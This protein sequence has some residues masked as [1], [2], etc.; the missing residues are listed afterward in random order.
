ML[1]FSSGANAGN[2]P[3]TSNALQTPKI[4]L[5]E[6]YTGSRQASMYKKAGNTAY[7]DMLLAEADSVNTKIIA[8]FNDNFN[9]CPVYYFYDTNANHILERSIEAILLDKN[10]RPVH[11][12]PITHNEY[13]IVKYGYNIGPGHESSEAVFHSSGIRKKLLVLTPDYKPVPKPQPNGK[14]LSG[15]LYNKKSG[16]RYVY[17]SKKTNSYYIPKAKHLNRAFERFFGK[18]AN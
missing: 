15:P 18:Q 13:R 16:V 3:D 4:I 2:K 7:G 11:F 12:P 5:V 6:L 17:I 1:C 14:K 9:F 8:D 10:L